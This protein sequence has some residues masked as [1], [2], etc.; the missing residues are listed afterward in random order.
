MT[1]PD[2]RRKYRLYRSVMRLLVGPSGTGKSY[3]IR[4]LWHELYRVMS[5]ATGVP[6]G[7]LPPRVMRLRMPQVLSH[8]LGDSDKNLDRFFREVEQLAG[9]PWVA[10]DGSAHT[11]PVLCI[12]EEIDGLARSRGQEPVYDRIM[13][14]ALERLDTTRPELRD[15]LILFV[16]T[17]NI[18]GQVDP[19][20][21]RR[22]GGSV[23]RFGRLGRDGF[24]AVLDK[25]LADRPLAGRLGAGDDARRR[26]IN[27][28]TAALYGPEHADAAQVELSYAGSTSWV[29][30][31]RRDFLTA[32][33]VD[34]AMQCASGG[35][36][37]AEHRG[38]DDAPGLDA[39][40]LLEAIER[41]VRGVVDSLHES[42]VGD[43]VDLPDGV[44]VVGLRRPAPPAIASV[45]LEAIN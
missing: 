38:E 10:P 42:N 7:A 5:E 31:Y 20:F 21:L 9:D 30:R 12:L 8:W 18:P 45:A 32:S 33:I 14:T 41:Q 4:A 6:V 11:L 39:A 1:E 15:K 3:S 27:E 36:S 40:R 35:A 37:V 23:E 29:P 17:T 25:Q 2:L 19:A 24:V 44:R 34:R 28:V 22:V 26:L 13:T 43:Y 16:A